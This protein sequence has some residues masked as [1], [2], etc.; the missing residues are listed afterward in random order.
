MPLII[1]PL[2]ILYVDA[3]LSVCGGEICVGVGVVTESMVT[4]RCVWCT[5][6]AATHG[7]I[8]QQ[9]TLRYYWYCC[10][11]AKMTLLQ[12][13]STPL[14]HNGT[15]CNTQQSAATYCNTLQHTA[16]HCNTLQYTA[17]HCNT[18]QRTATHCNALQHTADNLNTKLE[19]ICRVHKASP[20]NTR[21]EL[22][23]LVRTHFICITCHFPQI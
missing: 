9:F 17:T 19:I 22:R 1:V 4:W 7:N 11:C 16:I 13:L 15:H 21:H 2:V 3:V 10:T 8:P 23:F 5:G 6:A 18:L 14:Q 20:S 12:L